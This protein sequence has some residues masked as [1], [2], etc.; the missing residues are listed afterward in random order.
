MLLNAITCFQ[1]ILEA[2]SLG[3]VFKAS[4]QDVGEKSDDFTLKKLRFILTQK[5]INLGS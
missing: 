5:K 2:F 4:S 3:I 1:N